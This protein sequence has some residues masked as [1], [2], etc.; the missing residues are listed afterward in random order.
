MHH[1]FLRNDLSHIGI[2]MC[3]ENKYVHEC[4]GNYS[5]IYCNNDKCKE[6]DPFI[7][8]NKNEL[9]YG[10][11]NLIPDIESVSKYFDSFMKSYLERNGLKLHIPTLI[12]K[13][14]TKRVDT[15]YN[16]WEIGYIPFFQLEGVKHFSNAVM[17]TNGYFLH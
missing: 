17:E 10:Y 7:Y 2:I 4:Y 13:K 3:I 16:N 8:M 15:F 9:L 6:F 11:W 5:F 1:Y 12:Y 14:K